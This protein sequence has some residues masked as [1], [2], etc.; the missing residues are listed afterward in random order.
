MG[1]A[2]PTSKRLKIVEAVASGHS[3]RRVAKDLKVSYGTAAEAVHRYRKH[4]PA[5]LIP[6]Y[7]NNGRPPRGRD[8]LVF[9]AALC[10]RRRHRDWGAAMIRS[11]LVRRFGELPGMASSRTMQR[12]FAAAGLGEQGGVRPNGNK[13]WAHEPHD[14][15]QVDAKENVHTE[16]GKVCWLTV[17]DERSGA[18]LGAPPFPPRQD[19]PG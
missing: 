19:Q 17:V 8:C 1:K 15:W 9:R 3:I 6:H 14:V 18:L 2:I 12:W 11:V 7:E 4:G 5:G 16:M 13:Q 10:L